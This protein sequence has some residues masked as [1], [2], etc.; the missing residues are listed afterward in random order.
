MKML[1]VSWGM[2]AGSSRGRPSSLPFRG[3]RG[4]S[5]A[6]RLA[7]GLV[8]ALLPLGC[9]RA[10]EIVLVDRATALEQQAGGSFGELEKKL[11]RAAIAPRPVPLTPEQLEALGIPPPSLVDD[12]E[13]TDA[14]RVDT[15]VAQHC[16]GEANDGTLVDTYESCKG[17][18]DRAQSMALI[19]RANSARQQLWRWM[20]DRKPEVP[21]DQIRKG[22]RE[23]HGRGVVC[24]GWMQR[25]D[26]G[27][28]EKKC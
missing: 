6:R 23:A 8:A 16:V 20:R 2:F 5:P 15:L 11:A 28:E 22:W 7:L 27:W 1:G 10:P 26:G 4:S 14:D 17:A 21:L 3:L 12:K 24:G 13:R 18:A 19:E 25:D 9:I